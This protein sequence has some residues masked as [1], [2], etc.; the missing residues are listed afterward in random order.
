[1]NRGVARA[2]FGIALALGGCGPSTQPVQPEPGLCSWKGEQLLHAELLPAAGRII[3]DVTG[4]GVADWIA[5]GETGLELI[6][7]PM[8][9]E[10]WA[11]ILDRGNRS[12]VPY[13]TIDADLDGDGDPDLLVGSAYESRVSGFFGPIRRGVTLDFAVPDLL[14]TSPPYEMPGG[15]ADLFGRAMAAADYTG[16]GIVDLVLS[17]PSEAEEACSGTDDTVVFPGPFGYE[18]RKHVDAPIRIE[19]IARC[20]GEQVTRPIDVDGDGQLEL[21][22]ATSRELDGHYLYDLPLNGEAPA[23]R[24]KRPGGEYADYDRDGKLDYVRD[25]PLELVLADGGARTLRIDVP[26]GGWLRRSVPLSWTRRDE[27]LLMTG[28]AFAFE[29]YRI[30]EPGPSEALAVP[31]A[32]Y[33]VTELFGALIV[34]AGDVT[35]DGQADLMIDDRLVACP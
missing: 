28:S 11:V 24:G 23:P 32:R 2:A 30:G 31:I 22:V 1:M 16:D 17:A 26:P 14:L 21:V 27:T 15:L 3:G 7:G 29:L 10:P 35:G 18:H 12:L 20:M 19:A 34:S 25:Y 13:S 5:D 33:D 9:G 8:P 4:D 6:A